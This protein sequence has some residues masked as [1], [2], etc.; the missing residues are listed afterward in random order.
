VTGGEPPEDAS[1]T[2]AVTLEAVGSLKDIAAADWDAC[3]SGESPNENGG[4]PTSPDS[5]SKPQELVPNPF[6]SHAFLL[7]LETTG[8]VGG[9]TGWYPRHLV[10]RDG[11]GAVRGAAPCYLKTH[12]R[13]EYVFDHA[14]ADALERAG[15]R[16]Y[17][18]VQV[19]V[20]FTPATGPRLGVRAG[21]GTRDMLAAGLVA[22]TGQANASSAHVTFLDEADQQALLARGFLPRAD[23]QYH[24]LNRGYRDFA[25]VLDAMS[26]RK[27]KA[28]RRERRD[29]LS[30]GI[31]VV[32][33]TGKDLTEA[34]WDAFFGFYMDT[35]DRKWGTPYLTRPF[36]SVVGEALGDRI[37]LMMARR[38]G[39]WIAG[40]LNFVGAQALYG[41][42]WGAIEEHPFLHFELCYY[43][44][45]EEGLARGL[46]RVE[47]G[48]Q[49]EH[50]LSRGYEPVLTRS[51]HYLVDPGF[52]R[53]VARYLDQE[54]AEV[55][56][57]R[58]ALMQDSP[59]K[60]DPAA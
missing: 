48:A 12:S 17:P 37:V 45:M 33:L 40:A 20:P 58:E 47:A 30:N 28:I 36:F 8:C 29:A 49:G 9:R 46:A 57:M 31:E 21:S 3:F 16:Y 44:A 7:A 56:R 34:V 23:I 27:R 59:F 22:F 32:R 51:A 14:W 2:D 60:T 11:S 13:G 50:K 19:C 6:L 10:L 18:K 41:R 43:Q 24:F 42:H 4:L 35:G 25:D 54:R 53:A 26:S 38:A 5:D 1:P 15:G 39:R 52:R 55:E